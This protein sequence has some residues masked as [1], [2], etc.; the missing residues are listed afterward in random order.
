MSAPYTVLDR[1]DLTL[2]LRPE[3]LSTWREMRN[4]GHHTL[5]VGQA[6][7]IHSST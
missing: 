3:P 1:C 5:V 4:S 2:G 6:V 7:G